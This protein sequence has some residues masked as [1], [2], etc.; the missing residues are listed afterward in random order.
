MNLEKLKKKKQEAKLVKNLS[1]IWGAVPKSLG[2]SSRLLQSCSAWGL[3]NIVGKAAFWKK[4]CEHDIGVGLC[5]LVCGN[6]V[7]QLLCIS[8][9]VGMVMWIT[10][11]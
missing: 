4:K 10:Y 9:Q 5:G 6:C 8:V 7:T 1:L 3:Y 11:K 2:Y